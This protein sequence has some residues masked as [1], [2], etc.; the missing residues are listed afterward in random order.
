MRPF[1]PH[2]IFVERQADALRDAALDLPGCEHRVDDLA[3]LL[4]G[5]E[6][7]DAHFGGAHVDRNLG[8]VDRPA[9]RAVGVA[10]IGFV[11]PVQIGRMFIF[12]ERFQ[13]A[14]YSM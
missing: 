11:V 5:D 7:V 10:L 6:I 1:L 8:D 12:G 2:D 13:R 14:D 3:D 4:H 9:V